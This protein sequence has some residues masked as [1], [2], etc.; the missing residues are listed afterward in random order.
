MI[1]YCYYPNLHMF[2]RYKSF[3]LIEGIICFC[4][5]SG[6]LQKSFLSWGWECLSLTGMQ[7]KQKI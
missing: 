5:V 6:L 3:M 1:Y 4:I 7:C 2:V